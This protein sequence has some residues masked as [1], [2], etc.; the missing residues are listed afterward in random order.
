DRIEPHHPPS[1]AARSLLSSPSKGKAENGKYGN[2]KKREY[3]KEFQSQKTEEERQRSIEESRDLNGV[4]PLMCIGGAAFAWAC[5]GALWVF[6]TT[7]AYYSSNTP[8][9]QTYTSSNE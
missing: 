7:S 9:R 3:F 2:A 8:S 5:A 6:T 1:Q 4:N